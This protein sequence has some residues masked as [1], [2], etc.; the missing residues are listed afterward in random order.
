M[1][2]TLTLRMEQ[3]KPLIS[4]RVKVASSVSISR[5][6]NL[7]RGF[8]GLESIVRVRAERREFILE[9]SKTRATLAAS[10]TFKKLFMSCCVAARAKKFQFCHHHHPPRGHARFI[11]TNPFLSSLSVYVSVS[12]PPRILKHPALISSRIIYNSSR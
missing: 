8:R 1:A 11:P 7:I 9:K 3:S 2:R 12:S 5:G 4:R 10:E 6:V